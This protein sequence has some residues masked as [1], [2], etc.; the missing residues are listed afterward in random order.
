LRRLV[1]ADLDTVT[2]G[3]LESI[4]RPLLSRVHRGC[5]DPVPMALGG[6]AQ[7]LVDGRSAGRHG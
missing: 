6:P 1:F 2:V 7:E 4:S 3:Q 5:A